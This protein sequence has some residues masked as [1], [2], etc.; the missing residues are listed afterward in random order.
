MHESVKTRVPRNLQDVTWIGL[1]L[2]RKQNRQ[3]HRERH[4]KLGVKIEREKKLKMKLLEGN[5]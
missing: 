1:T 4:K 3:T 5:S 2:W